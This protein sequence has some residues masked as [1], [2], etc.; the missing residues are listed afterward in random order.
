MHHVLIRWF[1]HWFYKG[2]Y[3]GRI[4][5]RIIQVYL[6][7]LP[8]VVDSYMIDDCVGSWD[9]YRYMIMMIIN[10]NLSTQ[11]FFTLFLEVVFRRE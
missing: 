5:D 11:I 6:V 3:T 8:L 10:L 7:V 4:C 2:V 1:D 9:P